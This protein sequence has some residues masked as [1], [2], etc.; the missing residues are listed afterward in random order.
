MVPSLPIQI[1]VLDPRLLHEFG[2]LPMPATIGAGA[3]D[4]VAC[5][6]YPTLPNGK[7][8]IA[9]RRELREPVA[10]SG[11]QATYVGL[12]FALAGPPGWAAVIIPRSGLGSARG[13]V[14][15]NGQGFV[16]IAD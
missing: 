4:V 7:P 12:G 6:L 15:A 11:P 5:A 10:V 1:K 16:D 13:L 8:D 14:L 9:G 3:V 2:G